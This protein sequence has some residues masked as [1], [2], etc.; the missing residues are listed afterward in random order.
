MHRI[1]GSKTSNLSNVLSYDVLHVRRVSLFQQC[2]EGGRSL[3]CY[4]VT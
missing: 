4:A 2:I 1:L 3:L